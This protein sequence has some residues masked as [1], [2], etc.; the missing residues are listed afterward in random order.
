MVMY[1]TELFPNNIFVFIHILL[2][3]KS[4]QMA[5]DQTRFRK[6]IFVQ[7]SWSVRKFISKNKRIEIRELILV[8]GG[9]AGKILII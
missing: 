3:P 4:A 9:L 5:K 2:I 1:A 7:W 8:S 6:M